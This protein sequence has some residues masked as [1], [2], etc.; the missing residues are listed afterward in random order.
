SSP[1]IIK[2]TKIN[3]NKNEKSPRDL[4]IE[5]H[6]QNEKDCSKQ[7][8][9]SNKS[10][11]LQAPDVCKTTEGGRITKNEKV[12]DSNANVNEIVL[13]HLPE[14]G[15]VKP[16]EIQAGK[17]GVAAKNISSAVSNKLE[18]DINGNSI[19]TSLLSKQNHALTDKS[20]NKIISD[21]ESQKITKSSNKAT[22]NSA[23]VPKVVIETEPPKP[24]PVRYGLRLPPKTIL[25]SS[26]SSDE[27]D[28]SDSECS[29][30]SS[31]SSET[32]TPRKPIKTAHPKSVSHMFDE[33]CALIYCFPLG[34]SLVASWV[35]AS[36][37]DD[38][39]F[40]QE[41]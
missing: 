29:S 7:T 40:R 26:S 15:A 5:A 18:T 10:T 36:K 27:S 41:I 38:Y 17:V 28:S 4:E 19:D 35:G 30:T 1:D 11:P 33:D 23:S 2:H 24:P 32:E 34:S 31:L 39:L 22:D 3:L 21:N 20:D 9:L 6:K 13:N 14:S 12:A 25:E 8:C 16:T 37:K